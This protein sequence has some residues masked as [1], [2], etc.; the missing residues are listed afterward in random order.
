MRIE[1]D[2]ASA[3]KAELQHLS[4]MLRSLAGNPSVNSYPSEPSAPVGSTMPGFMNIFGDDPAPS[5]QQM[6]S[7]QPAQSVSQ[8]SASSGDSGGLFSIFSD[9]P[10]QSGPVRQSAY[11]EETSFTVPKKSRGQDILDDDRIQLY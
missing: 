3:T 11:S 6:S 4:D 1:I 10:S 7:P 5:P 9:S 8:S 2:T